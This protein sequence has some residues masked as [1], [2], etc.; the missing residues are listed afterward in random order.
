M[1]HILQTT[2]RTSPDINLWPKTVH[3]ISN[4]IDYLQS[5][6]HAD[7]M[8]YW[9]LL[10]TCAD[11]IGILLSYFSNHSVNE[12]AFPEGPNLL[13]Y[14]Q[15]AEKSCIFNYS[16]ISLWHHFLNSLCRNIM[17]KRVTHIISSNSTVTK[18][19][20]KVYQNYVLNNKTY[21][22]GW[23]CDLLR[24]S[25]CVTHDNCYYHSVFMEYKDKAVQCC[26]NHMNPNDK[27]E[28]LDNKYLIPSAT[29]TET[30]V[31]LRFHMWSLFSHIR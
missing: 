3:E 16:P 8:Q 28:I 29:P 4:I 22:G 20:E 17:L 31:F 19:F 30:G 7:M 27:H 6:A 14:L 13:F 25:N 9:E 5:K 2:F 1:K 26:L 15:K 11:Y 24:A 10:R 23:F 18:Y 21:S 12:G